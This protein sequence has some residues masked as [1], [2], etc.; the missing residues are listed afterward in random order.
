[1]VLIRLFLR[2]RI[3]DEVAS[4][5]WEVGPAGGEPVENDAQFISRLL[6]GD[7]TLEGQV[8][9][10]GENIGIEVMIYP[11]N[12]DIDAA[13]EIILGL[14]TTCELSTDVLLGMYP[15]GMWD[16]SAGG[17][18]NLPAAVTLPGLPESFI[19][20]VMLNDLGLDEFINSLASICDPL[21]FEVVVGYRLVDGTV[22][23]NGSDALPISIAYPD[24][25]RP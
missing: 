24:V 14:D 13:A 18:I 5:G 8:V 17:A 25:G 22:V 4:E 11:T 12:D 2:R 21:V 20:R 15:D 6:V 19:Y 16:L 23:F 7:L 1:M 10:P 9:T 3:M